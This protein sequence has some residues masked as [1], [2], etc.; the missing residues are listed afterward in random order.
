[1]L[2][3]YSD[4]EW[5]V[6]PIEIPP[7]GAAVLYTDGVLDLVGADRRYGQEGLANAL[8]GTDGEPAGVLAR[9]ESDLE[10]F[11]AAPPDD[12]LAAVCLRRL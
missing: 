3:A 11:A 1:M 9:L 8:A 5:K 2:G 4:A 12:D 6:E 7:G 10:A